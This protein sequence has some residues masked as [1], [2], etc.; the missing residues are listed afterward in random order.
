MINI[1]LQKKN[2]PAKEIDSSYQ[3][4][5]KLAHINWELNRQEE[6]IASL[7][8]YELTGSAPGLRKKLN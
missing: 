4:N 6:R 8:V 5:F 1:R 7:S 3:R 2:K